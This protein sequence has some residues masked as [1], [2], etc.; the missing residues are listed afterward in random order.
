MISSNMNLLNQL[1]VYISADIH[2][3]L[4][5]HFSKAAYPASLFPLTP[6]T[7]FTDIIIGVCIAGLLKVVIDSV[8][9]LRFGFAVLG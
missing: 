4:D 3:S 6:M 8:Q 7:M 1:H 2:N 9:A 5:K